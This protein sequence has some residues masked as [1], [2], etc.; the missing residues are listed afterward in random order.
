MLPFVL[1]GGETWCLT[2]RDESK[3]R[4]FVNRVLRKLHGPK[5]DEVTGGWRKL[6]NEELHNFYCFS[7]CIGV[8]KSED[9]ASMSLR[10]IDV[11]Y[12]F[13]NR[14]GVLR[15]GHL[16]PRPIANLEG[17][18]LSAVRDCLFSIFAVTL[19][20]QKPSPPSATWGR[21]RPWWQGTI[22]IWSQK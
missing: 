2:L 3:F 7:S 1:Y 15:L 20:I 11:C 19:H 5:R 13:L 6:L 14:S 17:Q 4:M 10:N 8:M 12:K 21:F 18:P 22:L 9:G 16:F